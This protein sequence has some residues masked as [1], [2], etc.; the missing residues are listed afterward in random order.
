MGQC[1]ALEKFFHSDKEKERALEGREDCQHGVKD[2]L[3][4]GSVIQAA[5]TVPVVFFTCP[6][7]FEVCMDLM[8]GKY[9][10]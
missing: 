5:V 6:L 9:G 8:F 3:C 10:E 7:Y 2:C 4:A 1:P